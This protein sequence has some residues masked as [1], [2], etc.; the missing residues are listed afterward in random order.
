MSRFGGKIYKNS[1]IEKL[2]QAIESNYHGKYR[3]HIMINYTGTTEKQ[4]EHYHKAMQIISQDLKQFMVKNFKKLHWYV[5]TI[6]HT[7]IVDSTW[8][9]DTRLKKPEIDKINNY[10]KERL[11][12]FYPNN[13]LK[14]ITQVI[15]E[16]NYE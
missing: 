6:E 11:E 5:P 8:T 16:V 3:L 15:T 2:A 4:K 14:K 9:S 10:I 7:D 1:D 12:N 13:Y